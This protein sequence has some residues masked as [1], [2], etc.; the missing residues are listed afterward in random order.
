M[1]D[2][3]QYMARDPIHRPYHH[4]EM[5]FGLIY[6]FNENFVL[7]L[8]HDEVVH[9]KGSLLA[10]DAGRPLAAVRQ[11]ARLL[12]L[13]VRRTRARSC[14]SWAA[15]SRRSASGTTTHSLDWHLLGRRAARRRAAPGARPQPPLP[16]QPGAAQPATSAA[17]ASS[18]STTTTRARSVLSF[19][20][21]GRDGAADAGGVQF[22]AR[23]CTTA[24]ASACPRAGQLAAS[25]STPIRRYYGG[26]NVGT[27]L[28]AAPA[29]AVRQP[30][31]RAVDRADAAAAGHACSSH[32]PPEHAAPA[33]AAPAQRDA[34][35]RAGPGRWARSCDGDGRQL[36]GVLGARHA[37]RAV[38]VR[39]RPASAS[40]RALP[41][42]ARSGEVWHGYLPGAGA[43]PG[44]RLPRPRPLATR[45]RA[46]ASTRTSCCSTP[47]RARSSPAGRLRL[48]RPALRRRPRA[49]AAHGHA[50]QR[51]RAR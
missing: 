35:Q 16:R 24:T 6:A 13:H 27:P 37:G 9:G 40:W 19:V 18:G 10:Q 22:H 30:R 39:R 7:P 50:R 29:E 26:S 5:T 32:G 28:G 41:L 3:L 33:P 12:R 47:R 36:R 8:S 2:T 11:P 14:C 34:G 51:P 20:R 1:H 4:G 48:A 17:P 49:P 45:P 23:W 46:T 15:S 25:G 42:P 43:G 21:R 38:P 44:L 31:P